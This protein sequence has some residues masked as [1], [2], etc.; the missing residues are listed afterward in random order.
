MAVM[1]R[2]LGI[3]SRVA[4]GY[5]VD[6]L[7]KEGGDSTLYNLTERNAF[8]WPEV[9]FPNVGWVEFSPTPSE[10]PIAR[11]GAAP[12]T[13]DR[14]P[15]NPSGTTDDDNP[16]DLPV[17]PPEQPLPVSQPD[18]G[19]GTPWAAM[20][21]LAVI[22]AVGLAILGGGRFAWER[23]MGGLSRPAQLWE[24]TQRLARWGKAGGG[25]SETPRE[26]AVRINRDVPDADGV[27]KLAATYERAEFGG[28]PL[29]DDATE[30]LESAYA[31]VRNALLRRVLRLRPRRDR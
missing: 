17:D 6:P 4:T 31:N 1:L 10:P 16:F 8:S 21:T 19:G 14:N 29:D 18:S 27:G 2:S 11:P 20:I 3:P 13:P 22:G 15:S 5:V 30:Q 28:K 12:E 23:G 7:Q 24:K 9:W 26:F 25:V